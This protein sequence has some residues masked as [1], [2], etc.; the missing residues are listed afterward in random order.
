MHCSTQC[1][2]HCT[3]LYEV[4]HSTLQHALCGTVLYNLQCGAQCI[5]TCSVGHS[6]LRHAV[7]GTV[8]CNLQCGAQCITTW[9][10]GYSSLWHVMW[11]TVHYDMQCGA[12]CIMACSVGYSALR[13]AVWRGQCITACNVTACSVEGGASVLRCAVWG[14]VHYSTQHGVP[15]CL[16]LYLIQKVSNFWVW[17]CNENVLGNRHVC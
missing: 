1:V 5:M 3:V 4:G 8:H 11:S 13:H 9:S 17:V 14:T 7:W 15:V 2:A 10:V 12:Q 16:Y 6:S